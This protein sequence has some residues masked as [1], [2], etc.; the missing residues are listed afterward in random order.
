MSSYVSIK[1]E[2]YRILIRAKCAKW[3]PW[4]EDII[5]YSTRWKNVGSNRKILLEMI[6]KAIGRFEKM[7]EWWKRSF[8][9]FYI[10]WRNIDVHTFA[11][12]TYPIYQSK[13]RRNTFPCLMKIIMRFCIILFCWYM[14]YT[15][16]EESWYTGSHFTIWNIHLSI[17]INI[18]PMHLWILAEARTN[19]SLNDPSLRQPRTNCWYIDV[20]MILYEPQCLVAPSAS[21]WITRNFSTN[22]SIFC[23]IHAGGVEIQ[24]HLI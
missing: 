16:P 13:N 18:K 1:R 12:I 10:Y 20:L 14:A 23:K 3:P 22:F 9:V 15:T 21:T 6:F 5:D 11:H 8:V 4:T 17:L 24:A 7:M 2:S 19:L